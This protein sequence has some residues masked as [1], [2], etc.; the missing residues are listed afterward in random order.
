[1]STEKYLKADE[2]AHE[3]HHPHGDDEQAHLAVEACWL[4]W[5][6]GLL[7]LLLLRWWLIF[8]HIPPPS[9]QNFADRQQVEDHAGQQVDGAQTGGHHI[10]VNLGSR[11]VRRMG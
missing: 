1:V 10:L 11:E 2:R 5:I 9:F 7:L 6:A 8:S 3:R 4:L